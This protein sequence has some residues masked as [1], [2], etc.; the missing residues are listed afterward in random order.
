MFLFVSDLQPGSKTSR[1]H[2]NNFFCLSQW[3]C[4]YVSNE[5]P[6]D[7]SIERRQD[8]SLVRLHDV[9]LERY[10]DVS[11]G[12][13]NDVLSVRLPD[14]L[15]KFQ[16]KHPTT[17]PVSTKWN[18]QYRHCTSPPSLEVMLSQRL[19]SRSLLSFHSLI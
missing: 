8:V 6:N 19:I 1:R 15:S 3:R 12:C 17:C 2:C 7:L 18:T 10:E 14:I 13:N 4:R 16:M 9:L 11:R 5:T